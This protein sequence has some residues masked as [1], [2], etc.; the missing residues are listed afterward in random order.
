[1]VDERYRRLYT[2]RSVNIQSFPQSIKL[3]SVS[4][5]RTMAKYSSNAVP[6][7]LMWNF[8]NVSEEIKCTE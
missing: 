5:N 8:V 3:D 6:P 1:M 7:V 4:E 2:T